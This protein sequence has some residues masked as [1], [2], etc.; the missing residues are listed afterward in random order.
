MLNKIA[1]K[2]A[3]INPKWR[4]LKFVGIFIFALFLH[5]FDQLKASSG[6]EA[7]IRPFVNKIKT[8][9]RSNLNTVTIIEFSDIVFHGVRA[10]IF[11]VTEFIP[12]GP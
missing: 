4:T 3:T 7:H 9:A 12:R 2:K 6:M 8:R 1:V 5:E 10:M 11:L